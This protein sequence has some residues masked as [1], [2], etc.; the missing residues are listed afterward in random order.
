[1][2]YVNLKDIYT[3]SKQSMLRLPKGQPNGTGNTV[4]L[5]TPDPFNESVISSDFIQL[6]ESMYKYYY[7]DHRYKAKIGYTNINENIAGDLNDYFKGIKNGITKVQPPALLRTMS[8]NKNVI[9]DLGH[10]MALWFTNYP[11]KTLRDTCNDFIDFL[12]EKVTTIESMCK[13]DRRKILYVPMDKWD[14]SGSLKFSI[15]N[16]SNI[17]I[18]LLC[19][20]YKFPDACEKL[21]GLEFLFVD[22]RSKQYIKIDGSKFTKSE[23]S[24]ILMQ[25]KKFAVL[26]GREFE[27]PT[28]E[29][30]D[31]PP[32]KISKDKKDLTDNVI[33]KI[34][35]ELMKGSSNS[36]DV[37]GDNENSD[38]LSDEDKLD[39]EDTV[40]EVLSNS[41]DSDSPD[42]IAE[43]V[44][45]EVKRKIFMTKFVPDRSKSQVKKI[46]EL[47]AKQFSVVTK[48]SADVLESKIID[49][50]DLTG[51]VNTVNDAICKSKF[52]NLD[53]SYYN[54][55]FSSDITSAVTQLSKTD[56]P[57]FVTGIKEEDTSDPLNL[58]KT[59]TYKLEDMNG[60]KM[61]LKFDIPIIIDGSYM[62]INGGKKV[63]GHQQLLKPIVKSGEAEVQLVTMKGKAFIK[64]VGKSDLLTNKI[65]KF[66]TS[67]EK[68]F[69]VK[70]GNMHL[71]NGE[72][73][74]TLEID[75]F[76]RNIT[77]FTIGSNVF[78]FDFHKMDERIKKYN[79]DLTGYKENEHILVGYNIRTRKAL[80]IHPGSSFSRYLLN[81]MEEDDIKKIAKTKAKGSLLYSNIKC[82]NETF[83]LVYVML[84]CEGFTSV[85]EK[86]NIDYTVVDHSDVKNYDVNEWGSI[87]CEDKTILWKRHPMCNTLLMNGF[88]KFDVSQYTVEELD[89]KETYIDL[90]TNFATHA[91]TTFNL[92]H[93]K[94]F[95]LDDVT[96]EI[97]ADFNYPQ[98]L[99]SVL[100]YCNSLLTTNAFLDV[101]NEENLRVRSTEMIVEI[102][103]DRVAAAYN[104]YRKSMH[105]RTKKGISIV[106]DSVIKKLVTLENVDEA[107]DLNP[108]LELE[109]N[110]SVTY[111]GS[112]GINIERAISLARRRYD[113]SMVGICG[114]TS[115]PDAKV[116]INRQLTVDP[117]I[118]STRGYLQVTPPDQVKNL[119]APQ[120]LTPSEMLTPMSVTHDDAQ[121]TAMTYKQSQYTLPIKGASPVM[122]G[123][124]VESVIPYHLSDTFSKVAKKD[125]KII[126]VKNGLY[127][128]EYDDGT[129]D[130]FD[131]NESV[132]RNASQGFYLSAKLETNLKLGDRVK[133]NQV[134]AWHDKFFTKNKDDMSASMNIG[135]LCKLAVMPQPDQY[136]D[137]VPITQKMSEKLASEIVVSKTC[138]IPA[139]AK[140][141]N[142]AK[143]GDTIKTG[144]PLCVYDLSTGDAE[145]DKFISGYSEA[146]QEELLEAT[147][148]TVK[149]KYSGEIVDI[150][151]YSTVELEDLS[152]SLE[153]IVSSYHKKITRKNNLLEKYSNEED[154]KYYKCGQLISESA[155]IVR[156][157]KQGEV[158]GERVEEG[159]IITF[160]IKFVDRMKKGDKL[161]HYTALKGTVS[162]VIEP[163]LEQYS[164]FRPKEEI[165]S[166]IAP[167][168]ILAR[169]TPSILLILFGNKVLIE[170]K[171]KMKSLY[172]E[173]PYEDTY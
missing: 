109:K 73:P 143:I 45:E 68:K 15:D 58:K 82:I 17:V 31:I 86:S 149:S 131:I 40:D 153:E 64:R 37:T 136:E 42:D 14:I 11:F 10:W 105:T 61:S 127:I 144:E 48:Q 35:A 34:N 6:K 100:A 111:K 148:N 29:I 36:Q 154:S 78:F 13:E 65:K 74:S 18:I 99:V 158:K 84:F 57:V 130:S 26:N 62:W 2:E 30:E 77:E 120:L 129:H 169:K 9:V 165:S 16:M 41:D 161:T 98:D 12:V 172:F 138:S 152:P 23:Y 81:F 53:K 126:E 69:K 1:M 8:T 108:I 43:T 28:E 49:P 89:S 135:T 107:S 101:N 32:V 54:K 27:E 72:L 38:M 96:K 170:T 160:F 97:L 39:I 33:A 132:L 51:S 67:N 114:I 59:Y 92:D 5:L 157:N 113:P 106:Q 133:A 142:I 95:V 24:N 147:A 85:M 19:A 66:I 171:R 20:A 4:Y 164:E 46:E 22:S 112:H 141:K 88:T 139:H 91:N 162:R 47:T 71:K 80:Y 122:I 155:E 63:I 25:L 121:R 104:D 87:E 55:K 7:I 140:V 3:Y 128:I 79:I 151:M 159:V 50:L 150:K 145:V 168:A 119:K 118:T 110:R 156:P 75:E 93:W 76:A 117:N 21:K 146:L 167:G 70:F 125:G 103:Y 137:S 124:K 173:T 94:M 102:L 56:Y 166:T 115:S 116:G 83:P 44:E 163:G 52:V 134:V 60:K 123:S 90:I